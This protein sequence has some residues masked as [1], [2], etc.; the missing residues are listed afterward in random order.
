MNQ[1]NQNTL[2]EVIFTSL[3]FLFNKELVRL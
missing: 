1:N 3:K 2:E